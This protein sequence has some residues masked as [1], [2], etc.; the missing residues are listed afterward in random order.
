MKCSIRDLPQRALHSNLRGTSPTTRR[1]T[2]PMRRPLS[3]SL[4]LLVVAG[5]S[6]LVQID[7]DKYLGGGGSP[8]D[9]DD[10]GA[11]GGDGD[12]DGD[13][14]GDAGD[15]DGD[16]GGDGGGDGPSGGMGGAPDDGSGGGGTGG[17]TGGS[18][19]ST[20]GMGT[21]GE[22]TGG[23]ITIVEPVHYYPLNGNL[24][25]LGSGNSLSAMATPSVT[26]LPSTGLVGGS[27]EIPASNDEYLSLDPAVGNTDPF[28][29]SWWFIQSKDGYITLA[30]RLAPEKF[31]DTWELIVDTQ[32][33]RLKLGGTEYHFEYDFPSKSEGV[34]T[35][36]AF[37]YDD[38]MSGTNDHFKVWVNG[39][40]VLDRMLVLETSAVV[41]SPGI[42]FGKTNGGTEAFWGYIDEIR[43]YDS[44]LSDAEVENLYLYDAP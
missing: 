34:W 22:G 20:G 14:G 10:D 37:G 23:A 39:T 30:H 28:T 33:P 36:I 24:D 31:E 41:T 9:G 8:G 26:L 43:V 3:L 13:T 12:G 1:P 19:G 4:A 29:I 25:D 21:G 18:G 2:L 27:A 44:F 32:S 42:V 16:T 15:G 6:A 11:G 35:H 38:K 40:L 17:S 7:D 5:C